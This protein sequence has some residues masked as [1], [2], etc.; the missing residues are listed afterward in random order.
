MIEVSRVRAYRELAKDI[1]ERVT[2]QL[3]TLT[4][5]CLTCEH[6]TEK[7]ELCGLVNK[8]PPAR[9][10]AFGCEQYEDQIPF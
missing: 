6:F 5:T 8:R 4:K 1:A 9:V 7:T 2:E 10:I 3:E